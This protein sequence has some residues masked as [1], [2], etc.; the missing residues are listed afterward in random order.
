MVRHAVP[1]TAVQWAGAQESASACSRRA[2]LHGLQMSPGRCYDV[3][4]ASPFTAQVE[5]TTLVA[6]VVAE[7]RAS[8][9]PQA[10]FASNW[11]AAEPPN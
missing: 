10:S 3:A 4:D 11:T 6:N 2:F 1:I 5:S 7:V 8:E 9:C